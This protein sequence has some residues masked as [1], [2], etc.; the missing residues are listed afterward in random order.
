MSLDLTST[1]LQID[2][3]ASALK[4]RHT[5]RYRRLQAAVRAAESFDIESYEDKREQS[6]TNLN[7]NVPLIP[8]DPRATYP[9]PSLPGD[10]CVVAVDGSHIDIDRHLPARCYLINIGATVLRYGSQPHADLFSRPTLYAEENEMVIRDA[11]APYREQTVDGAL[12]GARRAVEELKALAQ[13]LKDTPPDIPAL[14]LVD[15]TLVMFGLQAYPDFV[16]RELVAN[17]FAQA[18]EELQQM[19]AERALAV[20]SYISLPRSAEIVNALRVAVCPFDIAECERNCGKQLPGK[21]PCDQEVGGL[22]DR[23]VFGKWLEPC[24]R[25]SVFTSNAPVI[26][27][28]YEGQGVRFFYVNAG[29]E[30]G[31]VEVPSWVAENETLL[32]LAHALIIDQCRRGPGY[33][34]AI[35]EAHEQAVVTGSDRRYFVELVEQALYDQRLPVYSSEKNRS[36]RLRWL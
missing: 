24:Q 10:F 11:Y 28:H 27:R 16:V 23:E 4:A 26:K 9:P 20:A 2:Q 19:S 15:G 6:G 32:G 12:L 29:E 36:K 18:L 3:M 25:S 30:I 33:P 8:E 21:R 22:I 34:V 17:G 31:R 1:A 13:V 7:W 14:G 35:M 5:D